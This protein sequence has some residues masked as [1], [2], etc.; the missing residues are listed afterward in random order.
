M[1]LDLL[2]AAYEKHP[3]QPGLGLQLL[4]AAQRLQLLTQYLPVAKTL[5]LGPLGDESECVLLA[6]T[7]AEL[8]EHSS[9]ADFLKRATTKHQ[10]T[11]ALWHNLGVSLS[12]LRRFP[13][14]FEAFQ[15]AV[16]LRPYS[17]VSLTM[18]GSTLREMGRLNESVEFHG[19]AIRMNP[20]SALALYNLGNALQEQNQFEAAFT[21]YTQ[22]L[23]LQPDWPD[24]LNNLCTLLFKMARFK[25]LL[26]FLL[27]LTRLRGNRP[28]DLSRV[29]VTLRELNQPAQAL[30]IAD[31]LIKQSPENASY[32]LLRGGCLTPMGRSREAAEEYARVIKA[33]PDDLRAHNAL[34]YVANYLP[35]SDPRE[36]FAYYRNYGELVERTLGNKRYLPQPTLPFPRKLRIGYVSGDFCHHPVGTFIKPILTNHDQSAF[37]VFCYYNYTRNDYITKALQALPVRWRDI[38]SLTDLEFCER[39]RK[40]GIDILVDL[41]GHTSRNR[42][43]AFALKPAPVQVTMIGCMQTTGLS[44]IDYRLT[45]SIIDPVGVSEHLHTEKL[46]RMETGPLCFEAPPKAPEVSPLPVLKKGVFT[47][48]SFNNM[49]KVTPEVLAVWSK[50]LLAVP[51]A[52][53]QVVSD[54]PEVFLRDMEKR[55]I[56][57]NRFRVLPRLDE[58]QYLA[59]HSEVDLILDT[60]PYCGFTVSM[61]ALWMGV[62]MVNLMGNTSASRAGASLLQKLGLEEFATQTPQEYIRI[63]MHFAEHHEALIKIRA[64]LREGMRAV[65]CDAARHTLELEN[66]FRAMWQ[67]YSGE[68]PVAPAPVLAPTTRHAPVAQTPVPPPASAPSGISSLQNIPESVPTPR[69]P[70]GGSDEDWLSAALGEIIDSVDPTELL[71]KAVEKLEALP[72]PILQVSKKEQRLQEQEGCWKKLAVCAE[73]YAAIGNNAEA[74]RCFHSIQGAQKTSNDWAWFARSLLRRHFSKDAEDAFRKACKF[75]DATPDATL[76]LACILAQ[77]GNTEEAEMLCRQTIGKS[78]SVWQAYLNLG[79]LL[80]QKGEFSEALAVSEPAA[81]LSTDPALLLNLAAYQQKSGEFVK[82]LHTLEKALEKAPYYAAGYLNLGN[83]FLGLGMP[84][85]AVAAYKKAL[86][87]NPADSNYFSNFLHCQNYVPEISAEEAFNL[88]REFSAKF[89]K[90]FLPHQPHSNSRDPDRKLRIA[91][92]SPDFRNHSVA[93]FIEPLLRH[94]DR[95]RFEVVGVLS[96]TWKDKKTAELQSFCDEWIDAGNLNDEA[97]AERLRGANIDIAVDLICHSQG[98]RVGTFARKP[99]PVQITMIGMQQTTGLES[100][101]YRVTDA[102]MDPPGMS[103]RFHSEKLMRLPV[104]MCLQPPDP[105]PP[106]SPLP[107]LK[108]GVITFASFNNFAKAHTGVLKSWAAVLREIPNSRLLV[109]APNGTLLE[110]TMLAEGIAPERIIISPRKSDAAYLHMHD[111]VDMML[112]CFPFAGL[113]VSAIAAWMGVP[114]LTIVGTTSSARAGAALLHSFGLENFI[115]SDSADFVQKAVQITSDLTKLAEVRASMRERMAVRFTNGEAYTRAFE[116]ELRKAWQRWCQQLEP[117]HLP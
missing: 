40:D 3:E 106:V 15:K 20:K 50:V 36:L 51:S 30:E 52:Q 105:S 101:D 2:K 45:D 110:D 66:Q 63:A 46:A 22:A 111:E 104:S 32:R 10:A 28:E 92:V 24:A 43:P 37:E 72:D 49:A 107:A 89:E 80:Y 115:A 4:A 56:P 78:P 7:L 38:S 57:Q 64:S 53:M 97:L 62:P 33:N 55:G 76:G 69:L 116:T 70:L 100:V 93:Y 60:F 13:E 88:H 65:W 44:A 94:H 103:E 68:A 42:L 74:E 48:G 112:D 41:S 82:S 81:Q 85:E 96:N 102:M 61:N 47:F 29:A 71:L 11:V 75:P 91:Y 8:Q 16:E 77:N 84:A 26:P 25:Q 54:S 90:P 58:V 95:T 59:A 83:A 14:A 31:I 19:A 12:Q 35:Y 23:T 117:A 86:E 73:L 6:Q 98:S 5:A 9:A 99:A 18:A 79:A 109:V 108:T 113:T 34:V 17:D 1:Q 114:T 87:L 27:N 67:A 21:A 39:V